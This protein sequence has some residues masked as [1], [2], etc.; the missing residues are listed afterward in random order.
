MGN[1]DLARLDADEKT[2]SLFLALDSFIVKREYRGRAVNL[3]SDFV[4]SQPPHI[5]LILQ[6][7]LFEN[8]LRCLQND[9][10]T[11]VV[12]LALTSLIML[13]PHMPSSLVSFLPTLF[14]IYARLLFWDRERAVGEDGAEVAKPARAFGAD[15]SWEKCEFSPDKDGSSIPHLLGFFTILYGLYPINF[16]DYIRKPQRYLRHANVS[17]PDDI[18]VQPS[19]IRH[20]SERYRQWHLLHPN[21]YSLTIDSEKS[22]FSRWI[23]SEPADVVA[24]CVA[25]CMPSEYGRSSQLDSMAVPPS[26]SPLTSD[27]DQEKDDP[28]SALLTRTTTL[29]SLQS[30]DS[31]YPRSAGAGSPSSGHAQSVLMRRSS[32]SS[33]PSTR[34][35]ID[36]RTR[37]PTAGDSPTLPPHLV[38]STSQTELQDMINSNK[39]IK[40]GELH[41]SLANDSV[42]SL[43]LSHHESIAE[44]A[45]PARPLP[46]PG[47]PSQGTPSPPAPDAAELIAEL[48]RQ[49]LLLKNDL[50]FERYM[51]QQHMAHIGTLR[52]REV[53][54]AAS[55]SDTQGLIMANRNLKHRLEEA[56]RAEM[57]V[58]KESEKSRAMAKK[59]ESDLS[60]KL[61][62]LKEEQKKWNSEGESLRRE[63]E[64]ARDECER[65]RKVVCEAEVR[66]LNSKQTMQSMQS[67]A[68]ELER[69]K[70]EVNRLREWEAEIQ[71]MDRERQ[72]SQQD[73]AR[74]ESQIEMLRMKLEASES[75]VN[76]LKGFYESQIVV[77]NAKLLEATRAQPTRQRASS[78]ASSMVESVLAASRAKQLELQKQHSLL[79]RKYTVLQSSML[80]MTCSAGGPGRSRNDP[81]ASSDADAEVSA[82]MGHHPFRTRSQRGFSDPEVPDAVSYNTT[83]PLDSLGSSASTSSA[84]HRPGTPSGQMRPDLAGVSNTSPQSERYYGRGRFSGR[85]PSSTRGGGETM[86]TSPVAGGVQNA[87][88][89]DKKD[90]KKDKDDQPDKKDKKSTGGTL[91]GI[92]G[93]V[94]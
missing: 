21:F 84:I 22:D 26:A 35:S 78:D 70:G 45:A 5:H 56:K 91:R 94:S 67:D 90:K 74:A 7:S 83:P 59:W 43:S 18:E 33:Q 72:T 51:K 89:K 79:M 28:E 25:L 52:R 31:R 65:L 53:R 24:E 13:L 44:K 85:N 82:I 58:K 14:N 29:H 80:D 37:E 42:P 63:L 69:W 77:L 27:V 30:P 75:D 38:I 20:R 47:Q 92:R 88:R 6:T 16:M 54:E 61:R 4:Q 1:R 46:L 86:L 12:S 8:I 10:S 34:D 93:L 49:L 41:Q 76:R 64:A 48:R 36:T 3:L 40:S 32:Q 66:E 73:A 15:P 55:E 39:A 62:N 57:Q 11:T 23:K 68:S 81:A 9:T 50:N 60:A 71:A 19:E 2:Q 17:D 87:M